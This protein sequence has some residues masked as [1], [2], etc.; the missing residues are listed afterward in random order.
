MHGLPEGIDLDFLCNRT[1]DSACFVKYQLYLHLSGGCM[2]SVESKI[3][4]DASEME[5]LPQILIQIHALIGRAI[6]SVSGTKDGTLSLTFE[7]GM[8]LNIHDSNKQFEAYC[9]TLNGREVVRV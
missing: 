6:R 8:M 1:L 7:G 4:T 9:I 2:I 3:S 5:G